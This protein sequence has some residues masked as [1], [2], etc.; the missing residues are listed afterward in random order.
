M[1]KPTTESAMDSRASRAAKKAELVAEKSAW[2]KDTIDNLGRFRIVDPYFDR[3]IEG[4]RYDMSAQEV[5]D[6]CE[7]RVAR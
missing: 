6:F 4:V 2:R 1:N 5:I 7:Q 3:V